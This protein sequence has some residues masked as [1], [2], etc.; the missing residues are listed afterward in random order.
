MLIRQKIVEWTVNFTCKWSQNWKKFFLIVGILRFAFITQSTIRFKLVFIREGPINFYEKCFPRKLSA[1][2]SNKDRKEWQIYE[3]LNKSQWK[4]IL[5]TQYFWIGWFD[6]YKV[7]WFAWFCLNFSMCWFLKNFS[8]WKLLIHVNFYTFDTEVRTIK[9]LLVCNLSSNLILVT[10]Q[11]SWTAI[12]PTV[13]YLIFFKPNHPTIIK[14]LSLPKTQFL[15]L[16]YCT[17][18]HIYHI[19]SLIPFRF[20]I[21]YVWERMRTKIAK[22]ARFLEVC[23]LILIVCI[24]I[25]CWFS[26]LIH[27]CQIVWNNFWIFIEFTRTD[28]LCMKIKAR[29]IIVEN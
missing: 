10:W 15:I 13:F 11:I 26:K 2:D 8:D 4:I 20:R 17:S 14:H 12:P 3:K 5:I 18:L 23:N 19:F 29:Y 28:N 25:H 16:F 24:L 9:N 1:F 21:N 27:G 7:F 22:N 6:R